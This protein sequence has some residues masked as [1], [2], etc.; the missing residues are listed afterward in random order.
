MADLD[1]I[2]WVQNKAGKQTKKRKLINDN[3]RKH[4]KNEIV[5]E[6]R[7]F[8]NGTT[9]KLPLSNSALKRIHLEGTMEKTQIKEMIIDNMEAKVYHRT[10]F[11]LKNMRL[12]E[13]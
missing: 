2:C 6:E 11:F 10:F 13:T 9:N 3:Q 7:R 12:I 1:A 4:P 5:V 8:E